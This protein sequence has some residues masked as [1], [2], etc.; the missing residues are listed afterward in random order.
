VPGVGAGTLAKASESFLLAA[1]SVAFDVVSAKL[2]AVSCWRTV[3]SLAAASARLSSA[4]PKRSMVSAGAGSTEL[5]PQS[6]SP[7]PDAW[8]WRWHLR[9]ARWIAT[10][11]A[12][13]VQ[14]TAG[15]PSQSSTSRGKCWAAR[16]AAEAII[17]S[18]TS[19]MGMPARFAFF[20]ASS[21]MTMNWRMPS[22]CT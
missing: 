11:H 15:R 8:S 5:A 16:T 22:A 3:V 18:S 14:S 2:A 21:I 9:W 6:G 10:F 4:V 13:Q 12:R 7:P 1:V 17:T 19:A 20:C